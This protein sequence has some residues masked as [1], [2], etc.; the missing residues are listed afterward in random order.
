[1]LD[2]IID[3]MLS[4]S[5][6]AHSSIFVTL[7]GIMMLVSETQPEKALLPIFVTLFGILMLVSE[8]QPQKVLFPMFVT[9]YG[10]LILMREILCAYLQVFYYQLFTY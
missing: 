10:I 6:K 8:S 7:F 9:P 4:H 5:P 2:L 3:E 1:M